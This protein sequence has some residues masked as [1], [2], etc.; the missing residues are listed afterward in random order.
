MRPTVGTCNGSTTATIWQALDAAFSAAKAET[1]R[2]SLIAVRTHIGFGSPKK[3]DT[4]AAHGAPLGADEVIATKEA[5]GWPVEPTFLVPE[6]ARQAF[7]GIRDRGGRDRS[8]WENL[9]SRYAETHP[10]LAAEL[11]RRLAGE[12]SPGWEDAIPSYSPQDDPVATRKASG[13]VLNAVAGKLP[14]LTGGSADLAGSNNTYLEGYGDFSPHEP[15]GRNIYFGVREHAM[16]A[17]LNGMALSEMFLSFGGTFLIFSDYMRPAIRLAALME[18]PVKYVFTHDSIFVGEDGPTHQPVSQL[19]SLRS[20]PGLTVIR[21][22]DACETAEAWRVAL[23]R[24]EGPTALALSR[25]KLPILEQ[26]AE[27]ARQG[28]PKGAYILADP[29]AGEPELILIATGSEVALALQA[30][31]RLTDAGVQVRVVS[32]PSWELFDAQEAGYR[33]A[34]LPPEIRRRLAIEAGVPLGWERYVGPEGD[35]L[36]VPGFGASAPGKVLAQKYG[37]TVEEVVR[38]A[39]QLLG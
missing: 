27:R 7:Q 22:A 20:I 25:Q 28:L 30:R 33:E 15:E 8:A 24:R 29:A 9:V 39:Q 13:K 19:L 1:E 2:P 38:R 14:E 32:M 35:I 4:A 23:K 3:Q 17:I 36:G 31:E 16:G 21:P 26:T 10:D 11:L 12:M 6:E 5:L 37:F 34:I 18:L